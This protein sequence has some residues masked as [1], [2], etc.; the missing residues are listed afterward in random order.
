MAE[1]P[2]RRWT[3]YLP[4]LVVIALTVAAAVA[5]QAAYGSWNTAAWMHDFMGFF[6]VVFAMLKLFD[7]P[8]F[9]NGFAMY[10]LLAKRVHAYGYLYPFLEAALGLGYLA[11]L[12]PTTVA[13]AT[14][15]LLGFG[16]LGVLNA[17]RRGL[18]VRCACMGTSLRVPLSTV[19]LVEDLG[20]AAM[21]VAMLAGPV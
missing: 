6:L 1:S 13:W 8:G 12:A 16:A 7:L 21:A 5:K 9:A 10:D 11:H 14:I 4:L 18:N 2:A 17:L 20:M 3:D 15:V 19:A